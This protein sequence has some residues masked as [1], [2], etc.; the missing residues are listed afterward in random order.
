[1]GDV[2]SLRNITDIKYKKIRNTINTA[3]NINYFPKQEK[4][5]TLKYNKL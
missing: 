2:T 4:F 3:L 5:K 1:M